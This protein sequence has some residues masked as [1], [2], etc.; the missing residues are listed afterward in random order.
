MSPVIGGGSEGSPG[1]AAAGAP[2]QPVVTDYPPPAHAFP[3]D[4]PYAA[5]G[6]EP[7]AG[8]WVL[9]GSC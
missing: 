4:D 5:G 1:P 6:Y 8:W 3:E 2:V 7:T 9:V